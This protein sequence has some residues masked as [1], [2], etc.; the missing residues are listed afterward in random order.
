MYL[1][2]DTTDPKDT[3]IG[4]LDKAG[5]F[6]LEKKWVSNKNQS[7]ELLSEI[8][9]L[10]TEAGLS[11]KE[12]KKI[13]MVKG[14]GSYTGLRVGLSAGNALALAWGIPVIG[15]MKSDLAGDFSELIEDD[16][17][18]PIQAYYQNPPHITQSKKHRH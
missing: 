6:L 16:N 4:L 1:F 13:I 9:S 7:E 15:L 10:F 8:D 12:I 3:H 2:L 5:D 18:R 14:P 11:K 17:A